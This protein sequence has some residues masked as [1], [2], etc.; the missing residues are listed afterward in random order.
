MLK[1][2]TGYGCGRAQGKEHSFL[3]EVRGVNNRYLDCNVRIPRV[4]ICA[5]DGIVQRVKRAAGRGKIDVFVTIETTAEAEVSVMLNEA[6]TAGYLRAMEEMAERFGV[7]NDVSTSVLS[8]FPDVFRLER[9]P[10]DLE[11]LTEELYGAVDLALADFNA[12][13]EREG[14]K[15]VDD[16]SLHLDTLER[17]TEEV[18]RRSPQT[19]AEYRARLNARLQEVLADRQIDEGRV[20]TEAAIFADKVAVD[21]E[22]VRLR[23]HIAQMRGMLAGDGPIGRKLDFLVQEMNRE[24]N[25]IGSKANDLELSTLVVDMKAELEKL[26]EQIQNVE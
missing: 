15:L 23:S 13:R 16:L 7:Q 8:R 20:L 6:V 17:Y 24:T 2:M 22:T 26:R 5:E 18:E 21:E 1:S 25:T 12:M 19:V 4:Y 14:R 11:T 3:V 10:E 9:A